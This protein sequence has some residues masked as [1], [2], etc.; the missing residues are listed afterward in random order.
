[1]PKKTPTTLK[2]GAKIKSYL[3]LKRNTPR[4]EPIAVPRLIIPA[5]FVCTATVSVSYNEV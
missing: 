5:Q 3:S 1:M 4:N 2:N